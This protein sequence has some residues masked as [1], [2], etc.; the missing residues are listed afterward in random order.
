[1]NLGIKKCFSF[2]TYLK[3]D[4][5]KINSIPEKESGRKFTITNI[6]LRSIT[7]SPNKYQ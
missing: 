5:V 2:Q 1:M 6:K 3:N 7:F 4:L